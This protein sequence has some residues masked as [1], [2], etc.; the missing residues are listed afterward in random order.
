MLVRGILPIIT[1]LMLAVAAAAQTP[2]ANKVGVVNSLV[3]SDEKAGIT[4]YVNA[5]K[6]LSAEFEPDQK[7]VGDMNTRLIALTKEIEGLQKL[8]AVDQ[9]SIQP[10]V[11]QA[12]KLQRDIKFKSE[13]AQA[14]YARR[15]QAVLG[16]L[17]ESIGNA[18]Q[19]Y[20]KTKGYSLI[21]DI[22]KD[23]T[24]FLIAIGDLSVDVTN[25]F[26]KFFN[27]RP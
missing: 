20:A 27:A 11:E 6:A 17:Q 25:D 16:P 5:N 13:D 23:E 10:K 19:E 7:A 18:L 24:G 1:I 2:A 9:K 4:K 21:F 14:R 12:E 26:I 15:R 8:S 22:A 3:F